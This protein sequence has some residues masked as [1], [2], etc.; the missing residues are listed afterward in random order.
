MRLAGSFIHHSIIA[1]L[2]VLPTAAWCEEDNSEILEAGPCAEDEI[3]AGDYCVKIV[4]AEPE[5][6]GTPKATPFRRESMMPGVVRRNN[7]AKPAA[8]AT[9]V[10]DVVVSQSIPAPVVAQGGFGIQLGAW[11]ERKRAEEVGLSIVETGISVVL[12]PLARGDSVLWATIAGPYFSKE[13]A[14]QHLQTLRA[15]SRFPNAWIKSL[16]DMRLEGIAPSG[17]PGAEDLQ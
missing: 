3:D 13:A 9:P 8:A 4:E 6:P 2:L 10:P 5:P 7:P 15:D 16:K 11:S 14:Q 12:S 1:L 17:S